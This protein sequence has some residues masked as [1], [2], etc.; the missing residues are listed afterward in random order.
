[1]DRRL[2]FDNTAVYM[3]IAED[4]SFSDDSLSAFGGIENEIILA[5][6]IAEVLL[7]KQTSLDM[8]NIRRRKKQPCQRIKNRYEENTFY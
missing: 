5:E 3:D 6:R 8:P 2:I 4:S 7:H 1:M